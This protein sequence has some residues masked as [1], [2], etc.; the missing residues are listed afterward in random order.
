[1]TVEEAIEYIDYNIVGAFVGERTP[2]L[3]EDFI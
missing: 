2:M 1:M 3:L